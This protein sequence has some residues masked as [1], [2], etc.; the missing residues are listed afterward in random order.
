MGVRRQESDQERWGLH[1]LTRQRA[2]SDGLAKISASGLRLTCIWTPYPPLH[3]SVTSTVP[4]VTGDNVTECSLSGLCWFLWPLFS[5]QG[6]EPAVRP[7][8]I[9][10]SPGGLSFPL[11]KTGLEERFPP[12][13]PALFRCGSVMFGERETKRRGVAPKS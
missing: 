11:R 7:E 3:S 10:S 1:L 5:S 12:F 2:G 9:P 8:P 4:F 13:F 6:P